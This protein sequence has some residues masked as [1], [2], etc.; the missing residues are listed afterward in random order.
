MPQSEAPERIVAW[1][2]GNFAVGHWASEKVYLAALEE[3]GIR[4]NKAKTYT[5]ADIA[6]AEIARLR[7]RVAELEAAL[8]LYS[9]HDGCNE[10]PEEKRAEVG[11]GWTARAVLEETP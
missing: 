7:A 5:D 4:I 1:R 2:L 3:N 11:C 10:C 9:C 6:D 8:R